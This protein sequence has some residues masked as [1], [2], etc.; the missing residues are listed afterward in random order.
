M[1]KP[2]LSVAIALVHRDDRWLVTRRPPN[3]HLGGVWEFPG[4]KYLPDEPPEQAATRELLEE[5]GVHA[6]VEA[7]LDALTC[8]YGDRVVHLTPI[9]CRWT[10]GEARPLASEE[11][12]WV[13]ATDLQLLRMPAINAGVVRAIIDRQR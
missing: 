7:A 1:C 3:A 5:C 13:S 10:S 4:G 11:C 8:D 6:V 2:T 12:R 9:I